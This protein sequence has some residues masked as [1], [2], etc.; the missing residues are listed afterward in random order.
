MPPQ[1][2]H[3]V[4]DQ[5]TRRA[6]DEI[7]GAGEHIE[8]FA[9]PLRRSTTRRDLLKTS[10]AAAAAT[11]CAGFAGNLF[12]RQARADIAVKT[13]K[14]VFPRLKFS[15]RDETKDIWN[16]GLRGDAI[17]R[18]NLRKLTNINASEEPKT[19]RLADFDDLCQYPFVFMTS[20][21]HFKLPD[22]EEK[23]LREFLERGGFVHADD[24]IYPT[25][26]GRTIPSDMPD[27]IYKPRANEGGPDD[28]DRFFR[29]YVGMVNRL[30][31]ENPM[32]KVPLDNEIFHIYFDFPKGCPH[33][34]GVDHGMWGQFE[35]GTGRIRTVATP[36]DLHCGWMSEYFGKEKDTQAIK[37][38]INIIVYFLSH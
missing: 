21:G 28:M 38:G 36:G 31:P 25:A 34:Q 32:R 30:F 16:T 33:M 6:I 1:I 7:L 9:A 18:D 17:L 12:Q 24:C 10:L 35:P 26:K 14:F 20:E 15:V 37:M 29:D 23:N 2:I 3:R 4:H 5:K 11:M 27:G 8:H 13:G 19:V 22:N